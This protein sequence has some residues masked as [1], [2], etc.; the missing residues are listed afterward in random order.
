M[1]SSTP[2]AAIYKGNVA[3][4]KSKTM[5]CATC[6]GADG[7]SLIP[8]YPSLAGQSANYL[9]KQLADFKSGNRKD[10]VMAGMVAGLTQEDM[11]DLAAFFAVQ[12]TKAGTGESNEAGH[13]LYLGGDAAKGIT[14]C[15][16]CHG[17]TGKGMKQA[18]FP[19]I[20]G[21]SQDYLKKQLAS[22]RDG[23]RGNDNNGI[24]RNI[25]IKLSDA[26]IEAVSQYITSLK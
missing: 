5:V 7:N 1:V 16:A 19:S 10:P 6:H 24:M 9:A 13:K 4:G 2:A 14:A 21:Q 8:M 12:T 22:F 15:I 25:A 3:A 20:T 11:H 18:G 26:D 23:S 17:V